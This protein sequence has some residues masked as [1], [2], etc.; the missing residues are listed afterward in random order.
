VLLF[1]YGLR[2]GVRKYI[3]KRFA[4]GSIEQRGLYLRGLA[5]D[6]RVAKEIR[7]LGLVGWFRDYWRTSYLEWLRPLP[8]ARRIARLTAITV[9]VP[10]RF[11]TVRMADLIVVLRDG[12]AK[13][14]GDH[15]TLI[16]NGGI[17]AELC[18]LQAKTTAA[19]GGA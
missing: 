11:S 12:R 18:I 15:D 9:L 4:I 2:G 16:K 5:I 1:R 7:I 3:E 19:H 17:Y 10:H 8:A 14:F 6:V 13:G